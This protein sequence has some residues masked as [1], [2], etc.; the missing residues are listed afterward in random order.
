M[1][2]LLDEGAQINKSNLTKLYSKA[3]DEVKKGTTTIKEINEIKDMIDNTLVCMKMAGQK[4]SRE[5]ESE[6]GSDNENPSSSPTS[7]CQQ[8]SSSERIEIK[9]LLVEQEEKFRRR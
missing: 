8:N 7:G 9:N 5:N 2:F 1:K 6:S 3:N 4:R